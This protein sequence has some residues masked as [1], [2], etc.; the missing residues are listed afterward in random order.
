MKAFQG[1]PADEQGNAVPCQY[2]D[3]RARHRVGATRETAIPLC[4]RHKANGE[5]HGSVRHEAAA[6][7]RT[8]TRLRGLL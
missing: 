2:C 4:A 3:R 6:R 7:R 5:V 8:R 1:E